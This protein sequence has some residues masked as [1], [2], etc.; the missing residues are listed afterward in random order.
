MKGKL[1]LLFCGVLIF[2]CNKKQKNSFAIISCQ[3]NIN[4]G[5]IKKEDTLKTAFILKNTSTV[6]LKIKNIK[7]SCGCTVP[8]LK[9]SIVKPGYKCNLEVTLIPPKEAEGE[10]QKSIVI[11]ANTEPNFT[12][13]YLKGKIL[14]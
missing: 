3:K 4:F 7:T 1:I 2:S 8:N 11:D 14:N 9:D 6:D 10:V 13:L 12:V 5:S